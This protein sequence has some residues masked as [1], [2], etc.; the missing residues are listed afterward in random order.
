MKI[1]VASALGVIAS[2]H[3]LF[4][5]VT[6]TSFGSSVPPIFTIDGTTSFTT[7]QSGSDLQITGTD[8][9]DTLV[10]TFDPVDITGMSDFLQLTG[11]VASN[12]GSPF[13]VLLYDSGFETANY[14]GGSWT[15]LGLGSTTLAFDSA[16]VGFDPTDVIALQLNTAGSGNAINAT[17]TAATAIPEPNS[18]LLFLLGSVALVSTKRQR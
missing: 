16:S 15:D 14:T 8:L 3:L 5:D 2:C 17:L 11:S 18:L 12:P 13:T 4:A 10:G 1:L 7:S 9:G 6:L